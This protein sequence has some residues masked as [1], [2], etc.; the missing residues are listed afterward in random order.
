MI[1][2]RQ[3]KAF[4]GQ[5]I[6]FGQQVNISFAVILRLDRG[7]GVCKQSMLQAHIGH[8]QAVCQVR[9]NQ[10]KQ[11]SKL[12]RTGKR[13]F[14]LVFKNGHFIKIN[15][16]TENIRFQQV[17]LFDRPGINGITVAGFVSGLRAVI[18]RGP[19]V[20]RIIHP[21]IVTN[22]QFPHDSAPAESINIQAGH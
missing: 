18:K 3:G 8:R 20:S 5:R 17:R 9:H 22:G 4:T 14:K 19:G 2:I 13:G 12:F 1:N 6:V 21:V 15:R 16:F 7:G 11:R 10:R